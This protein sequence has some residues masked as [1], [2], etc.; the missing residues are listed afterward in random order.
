MIFSTNADPARVVGRRRF[1]LDT[2]AW[3]VGSTALC[4]SLPGCSAAPEN[5]TAKVALL[6]QIVIRQAVD[7]TL[8]PG[9]PALQ[10]VLADAD[11]VFANLESVVD[12]PRPGTLTRAPLTLHAARPSMSRTLAA[13]RVNLLGT[14]NNHAFDL[15]SDGIRNTLEALRHAGIATAG[16]GENDGFAAAPA[17]VTTQGGTTAVVA[18]ATG[19]LRPGAAA[20]PGHI[21]VNALRRH[22]DGHLALEDRER[23]LRAIREAAGRSDI[24]IASHHNHDRGP[25][26]EAVPD[27]QRDFARQCIDAGA[28]VFAGH[29]VP[30]VQGIEIHRAAPILHG[31]GNFMFQVA[32][33]VGAYEEGTWEGVVALCV[34]RNRRCVRVR[35]VPIVLNEIDREGGVDAAYRGL[36][37]LAGPGRASAI[38]S[39]L[40]ARCAALGTPISLFS[41]EATMAID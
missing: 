25:G 37:A 26:H 2:V 13:L 32:K 17:Y 19:M 6:G 38:L 34:F 12:G 9:Y 11:V 30:V 20:G 21:G 14:A 40:H 41:N 39:R 31:L 10:A 1:F 15:G 28:A 8:W 29:G 7:E 3:G 16:T 36:P 5:G 24:V 27:W 33:P 23:I 4:A 35:L 22:P 18:F